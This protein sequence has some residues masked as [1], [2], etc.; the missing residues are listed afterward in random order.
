MLEKAGTS[1]AV[2]ALGLEFGAPDPYEMCKPV[3]SPWEWGMETGR[4]L[5]SVGHQPSQ[6]I[7]T[8]LRMNTQ[9]Y[10]PALVCS[11]TGEAGKGGRREGEP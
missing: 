2:Q 5:R 11:Q 8:G 10:A 6:R 4:S 7:A 9:E 1:A 3:P